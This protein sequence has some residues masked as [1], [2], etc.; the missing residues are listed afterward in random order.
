MYRQFYGLSERPFNLTPDT[1]F[2]Y[3]SAAHREVL[4]HLLYGINSRRGFI[5][6]T[7]EVGAGKTT[8]CRVLLN[9]LDETT[10][11]AFI[12]NSFLSEFELL[13]AINQDLGLQTKGRTK[14]DLLDELNAYLLEQNRRGH[15]VVIVI[16]EAQN[17]SF[18]VLEQIR[19]L[20]NLETEKEKLLQIVLVG[21]PE[22][23]R[24]LASP[25]L[26]QLSQRITV[27]YHL[28]PLSR[29]DVRNY[30]HYRLRVAGSRGDIVFTRGALEEVLYVSGGVPRLINV[31]CDRALMGGYVRGTRRITRALV[32]EAAAEAMQR[33][34]AGGALATFFSMRLSVPRVAM[35]VLW[36]IPLAAV[37]TLGAVGAA[38]ARI[39]R[40]EDPAQMAR[41][42]QTPD[43]PQVAVRETAVTPD[44]APE[45]TGPGGTVASTGSGRVASTGSGQDDESPEPEEPSGTSSIARL[46]REEGAGTSLGAPLSSVRATLPL[47]ARYVKPDIDF[48]PPAQNFTPATVADA[49]FSGVAEPVVQLLMHWKVPGRE[50]AQIRRDWLGH[51]AVD[52][53]A[54]SRTCR[55][56]VAQLPCSFEELLAY[57]L[58]AVIAI[59]HGESQRRYITLFS[60]KKETATVY[61]KSKRVVVTLSAV[62]EL[63]AGRAIFFTSDPFVSAVRLNADSGLS[64]DVRKLQDYLKALHYFTGNATGWYT[65]DT[66][67]AVVRFQS[68][69]GL[70]PTREADL[71]TK[72]RLYTLGPPEGIPHLTQ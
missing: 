31:V 19:M 22:L 50:A 16:D 62:R 47:R 20:S 13:R 38:R 15:N 70:T 17:L 43:G 9:Q 3:P 8:L 36:M 46:M 11:V 14:M 23:R 29:E 65:P 45:D 34:S 27:R 2:L 37:A 33:R 41:A 35:A 53:A 32:C 60:I 51:S 39:E 40:I 52:V 58:P 44:V 12:L 6:V 4:T 7:G 25:R 72:L 21:Q 24:K 54:I 67:S 18:G 63:Y 30:I 26:R 68:D 28:T 61:I 59:K 10:K 55:M 64:L 66:Q 69:H 49:A 1:S 71:A 42:V 57:D 5:L 48:T 56:G